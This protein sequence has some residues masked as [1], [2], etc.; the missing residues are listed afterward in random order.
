MTMHLMHPS[1][2]TIGVRKQKKKFSSA[3]SKRK[4]LELESQWEQN[5]KKW[6]SMSNVSTKTKSNSV[7]NVGPNHRNTKHIPSLDTGVTG[8]VSSKA[9]QF[10]TGEN[11]VGISV[12]HKSCLQPVFSKQEAEDMAKM[13]R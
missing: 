3:E 1:F 2:T 8:A 4:H 11:L 13:R 5:Q 7:T 12:V 9:S 10:Y 6:L